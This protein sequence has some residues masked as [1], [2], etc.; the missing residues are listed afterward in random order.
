MGEHLTE[1]EKVDNDDELIRSLLTYVNHTD[2]DL[3]PETG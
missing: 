1:F 2:H 3:L